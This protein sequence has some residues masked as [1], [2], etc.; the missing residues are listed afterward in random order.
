[1]YH[2]YLNYL[3]IIFYSNFISHLVFL[4]NFHHCLRGLATTVVYGV[5]EDP[6]C[7]VVSFLWTLRGFRRECTRLGVEGWLNAHLKYAYL[8]GLV[9]MNAAMVVRRVCTRIYP[10]VRWLHFFFE[11]NNY[12]DDV[13]NCRA[14][15]QRW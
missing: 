8:R 3:I 12:I 6:G 10:D 2:Y 5:Y 11:R 13:E 9:F 1:M 7:T 14:C 15:M 4:F